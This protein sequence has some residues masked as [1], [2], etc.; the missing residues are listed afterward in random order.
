MKKTHSL[1]LLVPL[2]LGCMVFMYLALTGCVRDVVLDAGERPKVVVE[3]VLTDSS[4]QELRLSFT[5]GASLAEVSELTEAT[6]RLIDLTNNYPVGE[7]RRRDDGIWALDYA[8]VPRHIYRLEVDVPCYDLV[9]AEQTM[10]ERI[11]VETKE[12]YLFPPLWTS[13]IAIGRS[14]LAYRVL[15][16]DTP[17]WIHGVIDYGSDKDARY[18]ERLCTDYHDVDIFNLTGDSY[19]PNIRHRDGSALAI[20]GSLYGKLLHRRFLRIPN[21]SSDQCFF[22]SGDF[23]GV[24]DLEDFSDGIKRSFSFFL[25]FSSFSPDY[26]RYLKQA[27]V[28]VNA[29]ITTDLSS[30]FVRNNFYSN[31]HGG[32]GILGTCSS[33]VQEWFRVSQCVETE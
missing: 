22:V 25:S 33:C 32:I 9:W 16:A 29:G 19:T 4:P 30:I 2:F 5:K 10:P 26:D 28:T 27:F 8:A 21:V 11:V 14:V 23:P 20:Y 13:S 7:F 1:F 18:V 24:Y 31:I 15:N 12:E 3:C 6:A 17:V